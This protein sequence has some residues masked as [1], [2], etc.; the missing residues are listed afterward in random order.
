MGKFFF[1]LGTFCLSLLMASSSLAADETESTATSAQ[2]RGSI[3]AGKY[4][5]KDYPAQ[6]ASAGL[7]NPVTPA[8][9]LS[10][11]QGHSPGL[12]RRAIGGV[13]NDA[14]HAAMALVGTT[15]LNQGLDLP[16]DD[17]SSPQW[18]FREPHR[19]AV[20]VVNWVD[21]ST[22]KVSRLPD[23][24]WQILG[25]G[26]RFVMQPEGEG[27]FAL[28]GDYGTMAT[29]T[30][31]PGGG[32]TIIKADGTVEQVLPRAGGGF[33][34]N[35]VNG[36]IATI[37]PGVDGKKQVIRGSSLSSGFIQ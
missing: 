5:N 19:K 31:R 25:G 3:A 8:G 24:S 29:M 7:L 21:G 9:I 12:I 1:I 14:G 36:T 6:N 33:T 17:A 32:F 18:P 10:E 22:A 20:F 2:M 30:P 37:L 13:V 35:G 28:F 16:P 23:G 4:T 27:K 26:R 11:S 15:I 34:V